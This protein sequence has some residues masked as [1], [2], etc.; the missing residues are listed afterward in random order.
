MGRADYL[1][2]GDWNVVCY[3][4]GFKRKAS[5]ME[6]NWQ[7]YYVCPEHNEPRQTQD[8]VRAMPD[9]QTVPWSQPMPGQVYFFTQA[10]CGFGDGVTKTFQLGSGLYQG[11]VEL[12]YLNNV[13]YIPAFTQD[14]MGGFT[15]PTA[16]GNHVRVTATGTEIVSQ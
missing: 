1:L 4:C 3:Q 13:L 16:P 8:F 14:F 6:K 11:V 10:P 15:L 7:G 2:L 5:Q 9:N 12:V